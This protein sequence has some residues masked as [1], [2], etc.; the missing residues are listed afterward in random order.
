MDRIELYQRKTHKFTD[1]W[2]SGDQWDWMGHLKMTP[3]KLVREGNGHDDGGTYIRYA[4]L[5]AGYDWKHIAQ[6]VRDTM[7]N[8]GCRH[9]YDCCGCATRYTNVKLIRPRLM[10]IRTNVSYNY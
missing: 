6:S 1:G 9:E 5:P 2:A 3:S 10:Q 8:S 7:S 4:R